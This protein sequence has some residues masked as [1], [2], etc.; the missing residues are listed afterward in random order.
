MLKH[1]LPHLTFFA[2]F[3]AAAIPV[4]YYIYRKNPYPRF[5]PNFG[6][7]SLFTVIAI[8]LC[9]GMAIGLGSLFRPENDGRR[10][11]KRPTVETPSQS[12][13]SSPGGGKKDKARDKDSDDGDAPR[14]TLNDRL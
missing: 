5:R 13:G 3:F 12:G 4:L 10:A 14:R 8:C 9:A 7:M 1:Y 11:Y 6:E 2:V